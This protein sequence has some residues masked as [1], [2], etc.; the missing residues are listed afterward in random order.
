MSNTVSDYWLQ[1]EIFGRNTFL[2]RHD[3]RL[4]K[5]AFV[6]SLISSGVFEEILQEELED[7]I[8][9][10]T[11]KTRE[12]RSIKINYLTDSKWGKDISHPHIRNPKCKQGKEFRRKFRVPFPVFEK[13]LVPECERLNVFE[14]VDK[15]RVRVPTEIKVLTCLRILSRGTY[16]DDISDMT[17]CYTSSINQFF[18]Q[19]LRNFASVLFDHYVTP[20]TGEQLRK[21]MA[22]YA[23]IGL[24]GARGSV[25]VTHVHWGRCPDYLHSACTG[26]EKNQQW[27]FNV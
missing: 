3:F 2:Q 12:G 27:L 6:E 20:P 19:F 16:S 9:P 21:V 13:V 11:T 15:S 18:R 17:D 1:D 26:K 22:N 8:F 4:N 5:R 7:N 25:D 14:V 23:K 10:T 24:P